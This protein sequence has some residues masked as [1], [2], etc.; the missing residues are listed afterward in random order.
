MFV[1]DFFKYEMK[2]DE[3]KIKYCQY[4]SNN[5]RKSHQVIKAVLSRAEHGLK[6]MRVKILVT[7]RRR[8]TEIC[9]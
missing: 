1:F 3:I 2:T 6:V 8:L 4:Q 9:E 7:A 5:L